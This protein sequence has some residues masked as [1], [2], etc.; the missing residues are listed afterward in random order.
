MKYDCLRCGYSTK[1]KSSIQNHFKRKNICNPIREDIS[2]E[3][4][5][6]LYNFDTSTFS[7]HTTTFLNESSNTDFICK[8]CNKNLSRI[9]SLTR[10]MKSCKKKND[11]TMQLYMMENKIKELENK[12]ETNMLI[13][14]MLQ[15]L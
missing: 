9:D 5:C 11:E 1:F 2:I 14:S 13:T 4:M 15:K 3:D 10:H 12:L 8:H 7:T 6:K